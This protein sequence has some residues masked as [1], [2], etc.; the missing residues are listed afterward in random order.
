[1]IRLSAKNAALVGVFSALHVI[2]HTISFGLWR[3]WA[4][5]LEPIEARGVV[6]LFFG[7]TCRTQYGLSLAPSH[8]ETL[9]GNPDRRVRDSG[10]IAEQSGFRFCSTPLG[11]LLP[12]EGRR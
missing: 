7:L 6:P 9:E 11:R 3:N 4:I 2:L 10:E 12:P 5:Y 8:L 1:M